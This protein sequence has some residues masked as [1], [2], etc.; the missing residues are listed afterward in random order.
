MAKHRLSI[1]FH[2]EVAHWMP[3]FPQNHINARVHGHSYTCEA[4][5]EGLMFEK[6][7][8]LLDFEEAK[9]Q[10]DLVAQKFDHRMLNDV[11]GLEQPTSERLAMVL[12]AELKIKFPE[13]VHIHLCRPTL[14]MS[15]CFPV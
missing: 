9:Q 6:T 8:M 13:L 10:I 2:L 4:I 12:Y 5:F 7:G 11:S 1:A 15:V 14:G 3:N